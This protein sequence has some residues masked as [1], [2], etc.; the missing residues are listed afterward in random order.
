M[1]KEWISDAICE[2]NKTNEASRINWIQ[3]IEFSQAQFSS[4]GKRPSYFRWLYETL[5]ILP[6]SVAQR[7]FGSP[8]AEFMKI[9]RRTLEGRARRQKKAVD[10]IRAGVKPISR[11]NVVGMRSMA[12]YPTPSRSPQEIA[13]VLINHHYQQ[14]AA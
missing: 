14:M 12:A 1:V 2:A 6:T 4:T 8:A 7:I 13:D 9:C 10:A 11:S 3:K 5:S